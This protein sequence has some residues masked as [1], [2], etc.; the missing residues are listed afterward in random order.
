M[1]LTSAPHL[2]P[3]QSNLSKGRMKLGF[4]AEYG[5]EYSIVSE[6]LLDDTFMMKFHQ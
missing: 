2:L 3:L 5:N 4:S 1:D 6:L